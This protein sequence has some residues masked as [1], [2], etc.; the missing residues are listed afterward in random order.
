MSAAL[1]APTAVFFKPMRTIGFIV[2]DCTVEERHSDRLEVTRQPVEIGAEIS[3]HA[4]MEPFEVSVRY[5]WSDSTPLAGEGHILAIY[6][7]LQSL[8]ASRQPFDLVTGKRAYQSMMLTEMEV[9]TDQHTE[10]VLMVE[11]RCQQI[12][13]VSTAEVQVPPANQA[14][15]GATQG[16]TPTGPQ[17]LQPLTTPPQITGL[18]ATVPQL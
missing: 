8:Q 5:G 7:Q 9:T 2:P 16:V 10:N 4:F 1:T 11:A 15:P 6:A 13:I 18:T 3:D 17:Q 14:M 12:I